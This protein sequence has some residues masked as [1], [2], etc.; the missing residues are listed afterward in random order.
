[1]PD[2]ELF[3]LVITLAGFFLGSLSIHWARGPQAARRA[4]WGRRL[5]LALLVVLGA[6]ILAGALASADGLV[7]AGLVA[8]LLLVAM[9]WETPP[10]LEPSGPKTPE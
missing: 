8:G 6:A 4:R 9:L 7:P 1:M 5:F 10:V 2:L 3:L